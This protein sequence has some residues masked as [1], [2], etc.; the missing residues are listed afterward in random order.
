[1]AQLSC[2]IVTPEK[3]AL[4]RQ[5]DF[6]AVPMYDGEMGIAPGHS[7][8][9]GRLGSGELRLQHAGATD[10]YFL[11][12]GF[13][14]VQQDRVSILTDRLRPLA[15]LAHAEA[16]AALAAAEKLPAIT[17]REFARRQDAMH[18]AREAMRLSGQGGQTRAAGGHGDRH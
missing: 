14:Q 10:S 11:E 2:V 8:L 5:V 18:A 12:G 15:S 4:D 9:M 1:M 3:T 13:I 6:L 7:A 16:E 17:D